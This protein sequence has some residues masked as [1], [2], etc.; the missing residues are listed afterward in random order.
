MSKLFEL[1][2]ITFGSRMYAHKIAEILEDKT[3]KDL[4]LTDKK[5][6]LHTPAYIW[7]ASTL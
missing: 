7:K 4:K 3:Q 5:V 2:I 1:H 6:R